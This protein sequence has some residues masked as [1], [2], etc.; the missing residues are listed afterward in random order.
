MAKWRDYV[1]TATETSLYDRPE[2]EDDVAPAVAVLF[3]AQPGWSPERESQRVGSCRIC[4][5]GLPNDPIKP[6]SRIVCAGCGRYG[7][8][9]DIATILEENPPPEP[10]SPPKPEPSV[11]PTISV[12]NRFRY[13]PNPKRAT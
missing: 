13:Q 9:R 2:P 12:P 7:L 1:D 10:D 5:Y 6:G 3:G 4:G 8:D 11:K